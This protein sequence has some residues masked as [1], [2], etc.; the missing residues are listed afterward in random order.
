[1]I[2]LFPPYFFVSFINKNRKWV[3]METRMNAAIKVSLRRKDCPFTFLITTSLHNWIWYSYKALGA[4][5][6]CRLWR[7]HA[8]ILALLSTTSSSLWPV[9]SHSGKH[10]GCDGCLIQTPWKI[11][12]YYD[13]FIFRNSEFYIS[14]N[15]IRAIDWKHKYFS[16]LFSF[17]HTYPDLEITKI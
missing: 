7:T 2:L 15:R 12:C 6:F 8:T 1:M 9:L 13:Q 14:E 10:F 5:L 3:S 17:S 16:I 4:E 11:L